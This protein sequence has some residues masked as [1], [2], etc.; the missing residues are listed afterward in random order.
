MLGMCLSGALRVAGVQVAGHDQA[1]S[2]W[3]PGGPTFNH[4][5]SGLNFKLLRQYIE[6]D[7]SFSGL[8]YTDCCVNTS[9]PITVPVA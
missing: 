4:S 3:G 6:H 5:S 7:R 8:N 1:L 9:H 2:S